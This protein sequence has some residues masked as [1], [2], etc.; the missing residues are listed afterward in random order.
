M[1][2]LFVRFPLDWPEGWPETPPKKRLRWMAGG[3][4]H[5]P[6]WSAVLSRLK[7]ELGRL[8]ATSIVLSTNQPV[9]KDGQ[10]YK[11]RK[12]IEDPGVAVY[13]TRQGKDLA[14]A[15]DRY[16]L[17]VDNIRS[18]CLAIEGIRKVERHGGSVMLDRAFAGFERLPP[19]AKAGSW[20]DVFNMPSHTPTREELRQT[21]HRLA[22]QRHP[23]RPSGSVALMQQLNEAYAAAKKE[24]RYG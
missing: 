12:K 3:H 18:L 11:A 1:T 2:R 8:G 13:F 15:R 5:T 4:A 16:Q 17:L 7:K 20:R 10:P 23:D 6:S 14:M 19:P 22:A 21:Y 24:L 9:R